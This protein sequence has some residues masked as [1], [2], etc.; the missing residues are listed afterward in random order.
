M[1]RENIDTQYKWDLSKIYKSSEEFNNDIKLVKEEILKFRQYEKIKYDSENLY[2]L[3][4][5]VMNVNRCL[6]KLESYVSLLSDE[7]TRINKNLEL[8]EKVNNLYSDYIRAS[9]FVRNTICSQ[10]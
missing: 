3:M 9:Y 1:E 10:N 8:K 4:Q 2:E 6:D 7:D 5:L